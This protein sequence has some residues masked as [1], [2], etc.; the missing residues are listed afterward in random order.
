MEDQNMLGTEE[1]IQE[2][3]SI[4]HEDLQSEVKELFSKHSNSVERWNAFLEHY[5][6]Q[7]HGV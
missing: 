7:L 2:F 3:V 6:Q 1:R 4:L 5:K